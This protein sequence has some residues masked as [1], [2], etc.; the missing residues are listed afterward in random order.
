MRRAAEEELVVSGDMNGV[1]WGAVWTGQLRKLGLTL[2]TG[3]EEEAS[4]VNLDS[5]ID[6]LQEVQERGGR[7]RRLHL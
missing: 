7:R 2:E 6:H 3:A 1:N 4:L 5:L